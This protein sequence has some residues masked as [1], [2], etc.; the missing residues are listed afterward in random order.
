MTFTDANYVTEVQTHG[1]GFDG[2]DCRPTDLS[3][4]GGARLA[5]PFQLKSQLYSTGIKLQ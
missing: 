2:E 5:A 4:N 1:R 3:L